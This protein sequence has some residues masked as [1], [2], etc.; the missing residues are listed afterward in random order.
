MLTEILKTIIERDSHFARAAAD[1]I[2][3]T[4]RKSYRFQ[5]LF[6]E[7]RSDRDNGP[8]FIERV[9]S[10]NRGRVWNLGLLFSLW[11]AIWFVDCS[12]A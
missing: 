9:V 6:E 5:M 2:Q 1:F 10:K 8:G 3:P 7:I 12:D 11:K 4:N